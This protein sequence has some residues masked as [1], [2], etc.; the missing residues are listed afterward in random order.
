MAGCQLMESFI[1]I[2]IYIKCNLLLLHIIIYK[3]YSTLQPQPEHC[4]IPLYRLNFHKFS[5]S[6]NEQKKKKTV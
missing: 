4:G 5:L 6:E 2:S 3:C 1:L